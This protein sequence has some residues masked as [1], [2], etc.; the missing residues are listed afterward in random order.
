M[1]TQNPNLN[2]SNTK[3]DSLN[4][5]RKPRKKLWEVD[6]NLHCSVIGTCLSLDEL[7]NIARKTRVDI[8]NLDDYSIHV[9]FVGFAAR[10]NE[11]SK[12]IQ[13]SLDR[14]YR[15]A[16]RR[17]SGAATEQEL[18]VLWEE[19][20]NRGDIRG[21]YWAVISHPLGSRKIQIQAFGRLHMLSHSL[22][23]DYAQ[24][25]QDKQRLEERIKSLE[26]KLEQQ[27]KGYNR[28]VREQKTK[29]T[30]LEEEISNREKEI[31]R[32]QGMAGE[33]GFSA[34]EME[35]LLARNS[36]LEAKVQGLEIRKERAETENSS[37]RERQE[38][39]KSKQAKLKQK[40][41]DEQDYVRLLE[42]ELSQYESGFGP[43]HC[44]DRGTERCP[45]PNLCGRRIL[46]VGGVKSMVPHYRKV[47][48]E[49]G[50]NFIYHD[51]GNENPSSSI[52]EL[53][54]KADAVICAMNC[55]SHGAVKEIKEHC[56]QNSRHCEFLRTSSISSLARGLQNIKG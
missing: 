40:L 37:L 56:K 47:V 34:Q 16:I 6:A 8:Q 7:K 53:T 35:N 42:E 9:R 2:V 18:E 13:E 36:E 51:G 39:L 23:Q 15:K 27:K 48:E 28:K 19:A 25:E 49:R 22:I 29:I 54:R 26:Q 20:W 10:Q 30:A 41:K 55:V 38:S 32:L 3:Q 33:T 11:V 46:Y 4:P 45:G 44:P 43:L 24:Q 21:A 5:S 12:R 50:G 52:P 14:K 1:F 31:E 17:F